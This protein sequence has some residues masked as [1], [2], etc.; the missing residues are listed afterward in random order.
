AVPWS[1]IAIGLG[2]TASLVWAL[3]VAMALVRRGPKLIDPS[4]ETI[5]NVEPIDL[6]TD[7]ETLQRA[8]TG[9]GDESRP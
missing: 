4:A 1:G 3:L 6:D 2:A 5:E 8:T 9:S 7:A